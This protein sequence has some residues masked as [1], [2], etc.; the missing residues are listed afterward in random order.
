MMSGFPLKIFSA[1][2]SAGL[3][4]IDDSSQHF[5]CRVNVGLVETSV[6]FYLPKPVLIHGTNPKTSGFS[7]GPEH[8][9]VERQRY[10]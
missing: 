9:E 6:I 10:K 3:P 2:A 5:L 7:N 4:V 1:A 8:V